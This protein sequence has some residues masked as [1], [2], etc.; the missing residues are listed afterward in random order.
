MNIKIINKFFIYLITLSIFFGSLPNTH[1][2]AKSETKNSYGSIDDKDETKENVGIDI[3]QNKKTEYDDTITVDNKKNVEVYVSQASSFGV[4]IPKTII[5]DGKVNEDKINKANYLIR[6]SKD[7]N[8]S[9]IEKINVIPDSEFILTQLGKNDI[10]ATVTQDKQQWL[11]NETEIVGNGEVS[12]FGMSAGNWN[13]KFNFNISLSEEDIDI[14]TQSYL[15]LSTKDLKMSANAS[16]QVDVFLEDEN[17]NDLVDWHS[18]NENITVTNGLVETKAAA[19]PGDVATITVTASIP[20]EISLFNN[21]E[22]NKEQISLSAEFKVTVIDMAFYQEDEIITSLEIKQGETTEVEAKII[23]STTSDIVT[24]T[25]TA[26]SGLNLVKSGNKVTIK[27]A[28]DMPVGNTYNLIASLGD[29]SKLL[30]IKI[31]ED[32]ICVYDESIEK[33]P[34]CKEKGI[35]KYICECGDTY[36][37]EN[38]EMLEHNFEVTTQDSYKTY[39][40]KLCGLVKIYYE[41][42]LIN[43]NDLELQNI[44]TISLY[45]NGQRVDAI[46]NIPN[47]EELNDYYLEIEPMSAPTLYTTVREFKE[48]D[49]QILAVANL[50][51]FTSH[52]KDENNEVKASNEVYLAVNYNGATKMKSAQ[53]LIDDI[54]ASP[55]SNFELKENLDASSLTTTQAALIMSDFKGTLNG[56]GY[57]IYNL[58]VP[59]FN[60]IN[61]GKII[62]LKIIDANVSQ[63]KGILAISI[64]NQG[65]VDN[66][67]MENCVLSTT[68]NSVGLVT[69]NLGA[70]TIKNT[71][72]LNGVVSGD[73]TIG[74]ITGQIAANS[75]VEN[76]FVEA[77]VSGTLNHGLGSRVGGITGWLNTNG[78]IK[79]CYTDVTLSAYGNAGSGGLIGGPDANGGVIQDSIAIAT[80]IGYQIAGFQAALNNANNKNIYQLT[81]GKNKNTNVNETNSVTKELFVDV[82]GLKLEYWNLLERKNEMLLGNG[83]LKAM[84]EYRQENEI[85]YYNILKIAPF[86]NSDNVIAIGNMLQNQTLKTKKII[87]VY[88]FDE[89]NDLIMY[90]NKENPFEVKTIKIVYQDETFDKFNVT[91]IKVYDDIVVS[92]SIE[93][94]KIPYHFNKYIMEDNANIQNYIEQELL[95]LDFETDIQT[96]VN[97]GTIRLYTDVYNTE[98]K[99]N[100]KEFAKNLLFTK[101]Q[102]TINNEDLVNNICEEIDSNLKKQ[103]YTY[104]YYKKSFDFNIGGINISNLIFFDSE[105][106]NSEIDIDYLVNSITAGNKN[107]PQAYNQYINII[108]KKTGINLYEQLELFIRMS[109]ATDYNQWF[110]RNWDGYVK[111]QEPIGYDYSSDLN[112]KIWD[113][114]T[115]LYGENCHLL[116]LLT[117]PK[118]IQPQFGVLSTSSQL[119]ISE[120]NIYYSQPTEQNIKNFRN[121]IDSIATLYGRYYGTSLNFVENG[122]ISLNNNLCIGYDTVKNF[123]NP[124]FSGT[125]RFG[126]EAPMVKYICEPGNRIY[127]DNAGAVASG[128][129][130]Y[131]GYMHA[132]DAFETFTHE[133]A[134]NQDSDYFYNNGGRRKGSNGEDHAAGF[135]SRPG[136]TDGAFTMN[137][138]DIYKLEDAV[139]TNTSYERINTEAKLQDYYKH[140]FD[141]SYGAN[142]ILANAFFKTTSKGKYKA[143]ILVKE[144]RLE[145]EGVETS[146][147]SGTY[148][149]YGPDEWVLAGID[150]MEELYNAKIAYKPI[151]YVSGYAAGNFWDVI[152]YTPSNP[153]GI[154][155]PGTFKTMGYEMLGY[156]GWKNGFVAW[157][158]RKYDNDEEAIKGIT[159]YDSMK[160]YKLA[161]Y[162][163]A[164]ENLE[165]VPYFDT[166]RLADIGA[167][168]FEKQSRGNTDPGQHFKKI[169]LHAVKRVTK[170]FTDGNF[171]EKPKTTSYQVGTAEEFVRVVNENAGKTGIFIEVTNN[172]DFSNITT[173]KD[174]LA[175]QFIGVID[176]N[177]H[178]ITGLNKPLFSKTKFSV[179]YDLTF[180]G[181]ATNLLAKAAEYT[182]VYD[183]Y[184]NTSKK[185]F[186]SGT[187]VNC[188]YEYFVNVQQIETE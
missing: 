75:L 3:T 7:T 115:N 71:K 43:T 23:P 157:A 49:N 149:H 112:W 178:T 11:H 142:A 53:Q 29:F 145:P 34:T 59:L 103:L 185:L 74:A 188:V 67:T 170:D 110:E 77:S 124:A 48:I 65:L 173:S 97:A 187:T 76:C 162:N 98:I 57:A 46:D 62:N 177:E 180:E 104:T 183:S 6:V 93:G 179:I 81:S 181:N 174:Y 80:G 18:D 88:A 4:F 166:N 111:N 139:I 16:A 90:L 19:Q 126:S 146:T 148:Y 118:D 154:S 5:L 164:F 116:N 136:L 82:L 101:Y 8:I 94:L 22:T 161:R 9:G 70:S 58:N 141:S 51:E 109:G 122:E 107:M 163:E 33:Q 160:E 12:S 13:G 184:Y 85:S 132:L 60:N 10:Y 42:K 99:T 120:V 55:T 175:E 17:V 64:N 169:I 91:P 2:Y 32:H 113:N 151:G 128:T 140:L 168:I 79:K 114:L 172:L 86:L 25:S 182:M 158:S 20:Q 108:S 134:H 39:T 152:W 167:E 119:L 133:N 156:A 63:K 21:R 121:K 123:K 61:S 137:L 50:E 15:R 40:C 44:Q 47:D 117:I 73:N 31:I 1:L 127:L 84:P 28:N 78:S 41:D 68:T 92:Y 96:S 143:A 24:W 87:G 56:N 105:R 66:L 131:Y 89:N 176:G 130:A 150:T 27:I 69:G 95:K 138:A 14:P 102:Y 72:I 37:L 52:Y 155:D 165:D 36:S 45:K 106:L 83:V 171:Y 153:Y 159:N 26:V 144:A 135:L 30:E 129:Y 35:T 147:N 100:A 54:I 125:Q 186:G 38:I